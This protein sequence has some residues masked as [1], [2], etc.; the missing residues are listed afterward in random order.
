MK[1]FYLDEQTVAD[2]EATA[3]EYGMSQS[4]VVQVIFNTYKKMKKKEKKQ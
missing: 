2:I 1:T 3:K 4:S